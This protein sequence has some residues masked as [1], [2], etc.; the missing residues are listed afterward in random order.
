MIITILTLNL[1]SSAQ[2]KEETEPTDSSTLAATNLLA[3][4]VRVKETSV[5]NEIRDTLAKLVGS[6]GDLVRQGDSEVLAWSGTGYKKSNAPQLMKKV[7][8][9]LQQAGWT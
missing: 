9:N 2:T 7:E 1:T 6:G 5:P 3:T 8:T 4:A